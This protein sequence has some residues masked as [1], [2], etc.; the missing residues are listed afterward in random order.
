MKKMQTYIQYK[1]LHK[2]KVIRQSSIYSQHNKKIPVKNM[3]AGDK[4]NI[5]AV[6]IANE[7][8][9]G[10]NNNVNLKENI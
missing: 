5:I 8:F 3:F 10:Y 2:N 9:S 6:V 7:Y 1:K 4:Q